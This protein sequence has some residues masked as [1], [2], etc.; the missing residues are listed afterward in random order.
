MNRREFI[1]GCIFLGLQTASLATKPA[2]ILAIPAPAKSTVADITGPAERA[3]LEAIRM[4]GGMEKYVK[5]GDRV[6]VKPN[7]SFASSPSRASTTSPEVVKAVVESCLNAGAKEVLVI[8]H[9]IHNKNLCLRRNGIK[10]ALS[11]IKHVHVLMFTEKR[12]FKKIK[13]TRG[14]QLKSV[15]VVGEFLDSDVLINVPVAKSHSA[16]TVSLGLKNMMG[17]IWGRLPFHIIYDLNQAIADL[18]TAL[19][20]SLTVID[21]SRAL[22]SGGPAGPG[23]VKRLG[24]VLAAEDTV[25]VDSYC[26]TL[27]PWRGKF[28][29]PTDIEHIRLSRDMGLG[30]CETDKITIRRRVL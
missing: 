11:G 8:D 3:T 14:R 4:L 9:P 22:L 24:R 30:N 17:L 15:R 1:K 10:D 20:P 13:V 2:K 25:A 23:R 28:L 21:A 16:T 26:V 6:I 5:R 29:K 12:F 7:M 19:R 18:N 27:A